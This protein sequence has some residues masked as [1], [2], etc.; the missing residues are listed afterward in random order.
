[1][2]NGISEV[3]P[4]SLLVA[5]NIV[6]DYDGL[7]SGRRGIRQFGT[8]LVD[9]DFE[10]FQEF[11]YAGSKLIWYGNAAGSDLDPTDRKSTRLN[12]SHQIISY[13]VFCL[14]QKTTQ[15]TIIPTHPL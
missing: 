7:L 2:H 3:P 15:S 14:K 6:V 5:Q 13:A 9:S 4:G 8:K 10:V 11:F 12:S 1:M